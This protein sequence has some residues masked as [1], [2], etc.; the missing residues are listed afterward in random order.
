MTSNCFTRQTR[1]SP[2]QIVAPNT[3]LSTSSSPIEKVKL[4]LVKRRNPF[5][6][7]ERHTSLLIP[8][9]CHRSAKLLSAPRHAAQFD[10]GGF[11]SELARSQKIMQSDKEIRKT[12]S[13]PEIIQGERSSLHFRFFAPRE[14]RVERVPRILSCF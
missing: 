9:S 5:P 4:G 1:K 2:T 3:A 14:V 11:W 7:A 13:S 12:N 8:Q 10:R 6:T